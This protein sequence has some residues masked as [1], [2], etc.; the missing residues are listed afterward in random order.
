MWSLEIVVDTNSELGDYMRG[1]KGTTLGKVSKIMQITSL[2]Y[3]DTN[4]FCIYK[5]YIIFRYKYFIIQRTCIMYFIVHS[6]ENVSHHCCGFKTQHAW[7]TEKQ[8]LPGI[9]GPPEILQTD[10]SWHIA[11]TLFTVSVIQKKT[12][13]YHIR[14]IESECTCK[15]YF[16]MICLW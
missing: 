9:H 13:E 10:R 14:N 4:R 12:R 3:L 15:W 16:P 1:I 2:S 6:W 7:T 8:R 5:I 11:F